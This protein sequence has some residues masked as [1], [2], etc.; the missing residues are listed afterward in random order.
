MYLIVFVKIFNPK[1]NS[2]F[3]L[4]KIFF[5][6]N[7]RKNLLSWKIEMKIQWHKNIFKQKCVQ[8]LK[9]QY[10]YRSIFKITK[11]NDKFIYIEHTC[12]IFILLFNPKKAVFCN[13]GFCFNFNKKKN[14]FLW[15]NM[16]RNNFSKIKK[17][18]LNSV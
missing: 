1:K 2:F 6:L 18:K 15:K 12:I 3:Q 10:F 13:T 16:Q 8:L 5:F 4:H 9:D 17:H 7:I 14:I 11:K